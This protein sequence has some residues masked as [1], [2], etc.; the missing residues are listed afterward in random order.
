MTAQKF[1]NVTGKVFDETRFRGRGTASN[2]VGRYEKLTRHEFDDG[3]DGLEDLPPFQTQVREEISKSIIS[4]NRSP[5][6]PFDLSIN[7][8]RGCEHGCVYC[9]ARPTHTYWGLSAGLDFETKLTAR[10]N[11][12]ELLEKALAKPSHKVSPIALGIN[13]DA[14]QPIERRYKL[15]REILKVLAI[16]KHPVTIVTKSALILRDLDILTPMAK[17]GLVSVAFSVTSLEGKLARAMEPRASAPHRRLYALKALAEA[18]VPTMTLVAP[19]IPSLNDH[20]ME[21]ILEAVCE[22]GVN[23]AGYVLLRL[24]LEIGDLFRDWLEREVPD[25]AKRV[26]SILQSMRGGRDYD[27]RYGKRMRGEGDYADL[28]SDRFRLAVKRLGMNQTRFKL[29]RDLFEAPVLPGGQM[30]LF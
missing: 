13:T 17:E 24:P 15:T 25:R 3:W 16:T 19:V 8:Y 18:G 10:V 11:A 23:Q 22:C 20:E 7:P 30:R 29:R 26:M 28:L 14:Y 12:V 4:T 21:T 5:D 2:A 27:S 1:S 9:F 6:V